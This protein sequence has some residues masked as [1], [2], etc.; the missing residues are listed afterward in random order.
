[1]TDKLPKLKVRIKAHEKL[2][3]YKIN[4]YKISIVAI[5]NPIHDKII[6]CKGCEWR[7]VIKVV[8]GREEKK[9]QECRSV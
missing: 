8:Q 5:Y 7:K 9:I 2:D 6:Y 3:I 4:H 1:M